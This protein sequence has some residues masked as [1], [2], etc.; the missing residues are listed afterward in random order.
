MWTIKHAIQKVIIR[1]KPVRILGLYHPPSN[2]KDK[3]TSN[4]F[5]DDIMELLTEKISKLDHLIFMGN[6]NIHGEDH[7]NTEATIFNG[8][9][10]A[11]GLQQ[12]V[13]KPTHHQ[14]SILDLIFTEVNSELKASNCKTSEYLS[15]NCLVTIDTNIRKE[16][17]ERATKTIC[18]TSQLTKEYLINKFKAPILNGGTNLNQECHQFNNKLQKMFDKVASERTVN[19]AN[20]S[21]KLWFNKYIRNQRK[22]V[23]IRIL[24]QQAF[25]T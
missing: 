24:F 23:K 4:M 2:T 1:N 7:L 11:L 21:I 12:H 6:F 22:I 14:G 8:T 15:D 18:D 25:N 19:F 5:I 3:T 10:Q 9:M 17:R 20:N 16:P 13:N